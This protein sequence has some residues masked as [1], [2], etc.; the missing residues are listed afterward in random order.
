M[1]RLVRLVVEGVLMGRREAGDQDEEEY[2]EHQRERGQETG[3][4]QTD[5]WVKD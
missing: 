1:R 5:C 2:Q 3:N 4:H